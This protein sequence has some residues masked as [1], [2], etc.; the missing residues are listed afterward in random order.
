MRALDPQV[1]DAIWEQVEPC[2]QPPKT[3]TARLSPASGARPAPGNTAHPLDD[4]APAM[5][6][7]AAPSPVVPDQILMARAL[8]R[9]SVKTF[10]R[11]ESVAGNDR[12]RSYSHAGSGDDQVV[13]GVPE[14]A[15]PADPAAK[16]ARPATKTHFRP[17]RSP[18]LPRT[19]RSPANITA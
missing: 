11:I 18:R 17:K 7:P 5:G 16:T 14:K 8:S 15:E 9:S 6:P 12:R 13:A 1:F 10:E 19:N 3:I 2:S 4:C